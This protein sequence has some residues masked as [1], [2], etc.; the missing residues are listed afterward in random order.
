MKTKELRILANASAKNTPS[1]EKMIAYKKRTVNGFDP[2]K[3]NS[4]V[5]KKWLSNTMHRNSDKIALKRSKIQ[6]KDMQLWLTYQNVAHMYYA[7]EGQCDRSKVGKY[8][9]EAVLMDREGNGQIKNRRVDIAD[10]ENT[11]D[12]NLSVGVNGVEG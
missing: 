1:E 8:L 5:G 9:T 6:E 3:T 7:F 11:N 4:I 2:T 12:S 10:E